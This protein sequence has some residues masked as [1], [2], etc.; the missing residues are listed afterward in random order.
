LPIRQNENSTASNPRAQV[1]LGVCHGTLTLREAQFIIVTD[2]YKYYRDKVLKRIHCW[3]RLHS[4][5]AR[6]EHVSKPLAMTSEAEEL[7]R[8]ISTSVRDMLDAWAQ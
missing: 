3:E 8:I 1:N 5:A 7:H 4:G 6:Q 2:W